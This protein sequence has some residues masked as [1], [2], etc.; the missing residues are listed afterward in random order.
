MKGRIAAL[1]ALLLA[2]TAGA[3][4]DT[5]YWQVG[6][7]EGFLQGKELDG[8][9]VTSDGLLKV[10]HAT[11][12]LQLP[13]EPSAWSGALTPDGA[14]YVGT[15]RGKIYRVQGEAAK[16]VFDTGGTLV[17][18]IVEREGELFA[19][20][21]PGGRIFKM[22][23]DGAWK[24]FVK[25]E[26]DQVWSLAV[27]PDGTLYAGG[28]KPAKVY[29]I[30]SAGE[31]RDIYSPK[32]D[33]VMTLSLVER[34]HLLVGT[35]NPA[36]V[37]RL[38]GRSGQVV[39]DFGDGEIRSIVQRDGSV[40]V[41][42]NAK[43]GAMPHE[44]LKAF[45]P[46]PAPK[47]EEKPKEAPRKE[48]KAPEKEKEREKPDEPQ[49]DK[50]DGDYI[51][52]D[53]ITGTWE[54]RISFMGQSQ[55]LVLELTHEKGRISGKIKSKPPAKE[56]PVEVSGTYDPQTKTLTLTASQEQQVGDQT[57]TIKITVEATVSEPDVLKGSVKIE[58][59]GM[60]QAVR[61][62]FEARRTSKPA[63]AGP[64]EKPAAPQEREEGGPVEPAESPEP[65]QQPPQAPVPTL[66]QPP[67][68]AIWVLS[69]DRTEPLASFAHYV[70]D[71][72]WWRGGLLAATNDRGRVVRVFLDRTFEIFLGF[73]QSNVL[74][75][76]VQGDSLK[77][78]RLGD[79]GRIGW[80]S[81]G[82]PPRPTYLSALFDAGANSVWGN[83]EVRAAG[84]I[85]I[86]TRSAV[87]VRSDDD[88]SEWSPPLREFPARI[89]SPKGR[90]LQ[91]RAVFR[92][93]K[94][95][96]EGVTVAYRNENRRPVISALRVD[97]QPVMQMGQPMVPSSGQSGGS[98]PQVGQPHSPIKRIHWM[99]QDPDG[100]L[101][102]Y[103]LFCR[104]EGTA[105][106]IPITAE[107]PLL[108]NMF[109]WNTEGVPDGWYVVRLVA[110]DRPSNADAQ[111]LEEEARTAAILVDNTRPEVL[112][113]PVPPRG[114]KVSGRAVDA[115][116]RISALEISVNGGRWES[117]SP[118]DGLFD[119]PSKEFEIDL[120]PRKLP[121][122]SHIV[123]VRAYDQE[124]NTGIASLTV[125]VR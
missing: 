60:D 32:C 75:F 91:F 39:Y 43:T 21:L 70:S 98:S 121:R 26:T 16:E 52:F 93:P 79:P 28:G 71:I 8:V 29:R 7:Q 9:I 125:T 1:A 83:I 124:M 61:G 2:G 117:I 46:K 15:G 20:T 69:P 40:Y 122:G 96:L 36:R 53:D 10:G 77:A 97:Y 57:L 64:E 59:A 48:D 47:K 67:K 104:R 123:S 111:A 90:F 66:S 113:D 110:T 35:M 12:T 5:K 76:H 82:P 102:G 4:G 74:G 116:S 99:A 3:A 109:Q 44:V 24:E 84:A 78:V 38:R 107:E 120:A 88:L 49:P 25:L 13:D 80:V 86:R 101:L 54:G 115:V 23:S 41:A 51:G 50:P 114:L 56:D 27:A 95:V 105:V 37:V 45:L 62:E 14:L 103:R 108:T 100:D 6:R 31:A 112:L 42:H 34:E 81:D 119:A 89:A 63:E 65:P 22:T 73:K 68:S 11:R 118:K 18:S 19:S 94:A 33:F 58:V 30:S 92:D 72:A 87:A 17:T 55:E 106:W 85:E